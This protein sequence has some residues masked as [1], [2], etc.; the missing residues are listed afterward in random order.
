MRKKRKNSISSLTY[1]LKYAKMVKT[2]GCHIRN[3]MMNIAMSMVAPP[4]AF[5]NH[6]QIPN[7]HQ[8]SKRLKS[9]TSHH[10]QLF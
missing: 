6:H 2:M 9:T 7:L 5:F 3:H 10:S 8:E 1:V 4:T